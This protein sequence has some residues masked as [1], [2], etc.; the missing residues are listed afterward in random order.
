MILTQ[1]LLSSSYVSCVLE[2]KLYNTFNLQLNFVLCR[3]TE[4]TP[5]TEN[6][7]SVVMESP[8]SS[9]PPRLTPSPFNAK[10]L[11]SSYGLRHGVVFTRRVWQKPQLKSVLVVLPRLLGLSSESVWMIS[12][13]R[14]VW[15]RKWEL[16]RERLLLRRSRRERL[17]IR[18]RRQLVDSRLVDLVLDR[19]PRCPRMWS[20]KRGV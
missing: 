4:S 12:E 14:P 13:R 6:S 18:K 20:V 15:N 9:V 11:P 2:P 16:L 8:Y 1:C 7:S 10:S 3:N 17:W 19:G 5:E